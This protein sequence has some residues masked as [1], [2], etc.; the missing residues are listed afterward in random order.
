MK[1]ERGVSLLPRRAGSMADID[2]DD[3]RA[4]AI[5]ARAARRLIPVMAL[6]YVASFLDRV[7]IGFA[8]LTMNHDLGF[9]P[10]VF[11]IGAG[12]FFFG[13]FFFEIPSNLMLEKVGA[14]IWMCRIMVTWGLV[15]MATAFVRG[16]TSFYVLRFLLGLAEAGLYPGM[17]LYMTYWFPQAT[18]ARF[19][20]LFLAAVPAASVI[21]AP[22]SGWLLGFDGALRGWQWMLLLEGIPSLLLGAAVLWLLPDR[23]ANA[24][25]LSP[26]DKTILAARLA[27]D[28]REDT[29]LGA[30]TGFWEMLTDKRIWIFIIPDFSIVIGLYGMGLWMPQM[31]KAMGFSN[32][33]TGFLVA[34][35]YIVSMIGMVLLG[36]SSDRSGDRIWHVAG[37]AFAGALG[38]LGAVLFT[39]PVAVMVSFC[40]AAFGIYGALAVFWTLPTAILRGMAAA[41]GLAL[42][43]SFSNLG[44]FFG[45]TLM[46]WLKQTTGTYTLGMSLLALMLVFAGISTV[47]IG[48]AFFPAA[49]T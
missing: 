42:L 2:R 15:S 23:P 32:L 31:I 25:W 22:V 5:L 10:Q 4:D 27:D 49:K 43:N 44:G 12:I 37:A 47:V 6:M 9:S 14:R 3:S 21:G 28:R 39:S 40:V 18:R 17:I 19:I 13:Y 20:S 7:N 41:G 34:L 1:S 45:P 36:L 38:L 35:P 8:A 24:S 16:P 48:R 29:K 46:G 26:E 30:L 11:G 33:E